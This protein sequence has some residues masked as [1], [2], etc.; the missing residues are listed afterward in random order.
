MHILPYIESKIVRKLG[1]K[2]T[3]AEVIRAICDEFI[4]ENSRQQVNIEGLLRD[5]VI[6]ELQTSNDL[7]YIFDH[8]VAEVKIILQFGSFPKFIE[9]AS[10]TNI[11]TAESQTRQFF[12]MLI[13]LLSIGIGIMLIILEF[14]NDPKVFHWFRLLLYFPMSFALGMYYSGKKKICQLCL[15][16]NVTTVN[17]KRTLIMA[18]F[19]GE[20]AKVAD[21]YAQKR[22]K[23]LSESISPL[24][25]RTT[26]VLLAIIFVLPPYNNFA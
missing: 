21:E 7:Y 2:A 10:T 11:T 6:K 18:H 23:E 12:G 9:V 20:T 13:C 22:I 17:S 4:L 1:P 16:L 3:M 24:S 15:S 8:V 5:K 25:I 14:K 26:L 19:Y